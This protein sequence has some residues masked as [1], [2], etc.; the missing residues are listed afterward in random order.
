MAMR[1]A[2]RVSWIR[3]LLK[4]VL[5][6][7]F[8]DA[9]RRRRAL[10]RYLHGLAYEVHDRQRIHQLEQLEDKLLAR[11][12]DVTSRLMNDMVKRTDMLVR[13]L[14]RRIEGVGGRHGTELGELRREVQALRASVEALR[15]EIHDR[16]AADASAAG[17]AID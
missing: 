9:Y 6:A 10:R 3:Q 1:Y 4:R 11:R 17:S 7:R 16:Q 13:Q 15:A 8:V 2:F 14:D 12:P 5:P